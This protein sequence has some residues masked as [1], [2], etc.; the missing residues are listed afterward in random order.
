MGEVRRRKRKRFFDR[1]EFHAK[2][3]LYPPLDP[4]FI[5]VNMEPK[6]TRLRIEVGVV[7]REKEV[8]AKKGCR[9]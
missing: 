2:F 7:N 4:S 3:R 1:I 9:V 8:S 5:R 6:L